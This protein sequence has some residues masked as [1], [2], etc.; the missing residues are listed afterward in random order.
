M[1]SNYKLLNEQFKRLKYSLK[2]ERVKN[3]NTISKNNLKLIDINLNFRNPFKISK[4][5]ASRFV[6]S[7]LD[8]AH[9][10]AQKKD[11]AGIINCAIDKKLLNKKQ[12]GVTEY[13]AAK[14]GGKDN[15]HVML[16][17]NKK[18]LL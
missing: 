4:K 2:I 12:N 14:C 6:I 16:I 1:I 8:L 3:L 10:E 7:S 18:N 9:R 13:L 15:S 5:T 11:V 17:H